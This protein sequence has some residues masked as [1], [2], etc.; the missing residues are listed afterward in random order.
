V[1]EI[2]K[3]VS[4]LN[5]TRVA[6]T[7]TIKATNFTLTPAIRA[8]AEEKIGSLSKYDE[9]LQLARVELAALTEHRTREQFRAETTIDAPH[10]VFRAEATSEDLY[11]AIDLLV[12]KLALQLEKNKD[13]KRSRIRTFLRKIKEK[14]AGE[15][16]L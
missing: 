13:K 9:R 6:M 5:I 14:L 7:I 10:H 16:K 11:A 3:Y 2:Q 1:E 15:Q 12:P 4:K 8:Y